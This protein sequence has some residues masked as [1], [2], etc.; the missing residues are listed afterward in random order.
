MRRRTRDVNSARGDIDHKQ[1][2]VR[3]QAASCPDL[4]REEVGG[5]NQMG[6]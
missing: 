3:H 5:G 6:M 4:G 2:V 1:R